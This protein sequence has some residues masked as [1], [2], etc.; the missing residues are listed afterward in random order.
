MYFNFWTGLLCWWTQ[1]AERLPFR[2]VRFQFSGYFLFRVLHLFLFCFY[3]WF[4]SCPNSV[5]FRSCYFSCSAPITDSVSVPVPVSF[6]VPLSFPFPAPILV[7]APAPFIVLFTLLFHVNP[8]FLIL[9]LLLF[10][11]WLWKVRHA[12]RVPVPVSRSFSIPFPIPRYFSIDSDP[13]TADNFYQCQYLTRTRIRG[14][15]WTKGG[16]GG[17]RSPAIEGV[18]ESQFGRLK[19]GKYSVYS[20]HFQVRPREFFAWRRRD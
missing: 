1:P 15:S 12:V 13:A 11:S 7:P 6:T 8:L 4:C 20:V 16:G 10:C 14:P 3:S 18:G 9:F 2:Q 19:K 5:L 17:V